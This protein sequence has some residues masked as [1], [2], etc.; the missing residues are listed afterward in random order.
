MRR[1][2]GLVLRLAF[3]RRGAALAGGML[4]AACAVLRFADFAW[5]SALSD[6]VGLLLGATG[7]AL[8]LAAA[9]GRRPDWVEP[10]R[11]EP[12]GGAAG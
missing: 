5:E 8:L 10:G 3:A 4:I 2:R 6:G 12:G 11:V 9:G 1:A 7:A